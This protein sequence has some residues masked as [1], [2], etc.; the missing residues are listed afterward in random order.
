MADDV[1]FDIE[2]DGKSPADLDDELKGV[3]KRAEKS[4]YAAMEGLG[5]KVERD[6]KKNIVDNGQVDTGNML[7]SVESRT[8]R[9]VTAGIDTRVAVP[10]QYAIY[11]E[12]LHSPFLRPAVEDNLSFAEKLLG[13]TLASPFKDRL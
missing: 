1:D 4:Q 12:V 5:L 7:N 3:L 13:E 8:R 11:Q 10:T 2:W 9:T 6:T